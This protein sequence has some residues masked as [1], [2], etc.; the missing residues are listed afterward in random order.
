[1][2]LDMYDPASQVKVEEP[3]VEKA[4]A[5]PEAPCC[6][7]CE[8]VKEKYFS[9]D[10]KHGHCGEC[11]MDPKH[12][13]GFKIFEHNLTLAN[14]KTCADFGYSIYE[15]TEKHGFGPISMTLDMYNPT[16]KVAA[17]EAPCCKTCEGVKE[18]YFSVDTKH[19]H[20]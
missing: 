7:T 13:S 15:K 1:M 20:C 18:K 16:K 12:Y 11:C 2:T 8:G 3:K 14:G 19:G 4:V 5:A 10:T 6:K 9:V 17:P